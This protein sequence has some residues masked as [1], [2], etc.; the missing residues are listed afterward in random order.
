VAD[1]RLIAKAQS[2]RLVIPVAA[3]VA[4]LVGFG[5]SSLVLV[6]MLHHWITP[7][8]VIRL[9]PLSSLLAMA[10]SLGLSPWLP[11]LNVT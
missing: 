2:R 11:A 1:Q 7:M 3:V 6:M 8:P 10:T 5:V 4:G 9:M